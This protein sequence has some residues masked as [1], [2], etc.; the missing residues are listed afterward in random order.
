LVRFYSVCALELRPYR[1][2]GKLLAV[3]AVVFFT[4]SQACAIAL[5]LW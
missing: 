3:K 5:V 1:P 2:V 4:Y